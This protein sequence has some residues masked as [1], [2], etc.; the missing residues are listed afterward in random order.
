MG[1]AALPLI[2]SSKAGALSH[3]M[4]GLGGGTHVVSAHYQPG[5]R[6]CRLTPTHEARSDTVPISQNTE[7]GSDKSNEQMV[8][9][10][11][12]PTSI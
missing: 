4:E 9:R 10:G 3:P 5:A 2:P 6:R 1:R 7:Q 8:V 12:E 11:F